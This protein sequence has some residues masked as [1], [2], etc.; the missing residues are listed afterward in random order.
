M[1][2]LIKA[3]DE[4]ATSFEGVSENDFKRV[5]EA[6]N[7][8]LSQI[9]TEIVVPTIKDESKREDII[10]VLR[11]LA[12]D[13]A[14]KVAAKA[15]GGVKMFSFGYNPDYEELG[16]TPTNFISDFKDI[17]EEAVVIDFACVNK[18]FK[19]VFQH[20]WY[21]LRSGVLI[22]EIFAGTADAPDKMFDSVYN[23]LASK[24]SAYLEQY[25]ERIS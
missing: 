4:R 8:V 20:N 15:V 25:K 12:T 11:Y 10:K 17:S 22:Q 24:W 5:K 14:Q 18:P 23:D 6:R 16:I 9:C 2:L 21:K 7:M 19:Q 13:N 3:I 1:S